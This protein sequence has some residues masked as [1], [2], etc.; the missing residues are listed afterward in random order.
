M[1]AVIVLCHGQINTHI[2]L[3]ISIDIK[4]SV[5]IMRAASRPYKHIY[6]YI[7]YIQIQIKW[8]K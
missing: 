5:I 1:N 7:Y 8:F 2:L 6:R 4:I 3:F